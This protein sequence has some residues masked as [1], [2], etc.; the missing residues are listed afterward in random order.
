M[1]YYSID[2]DAL[3]SLPRAERFRALGDMQD[4]IVRATSAER[5]RLAAEETA[6]QA[7]AHGVWGSQRRA[8]E[9]LGIKQTYL[10]SLVKN[11]KNKE[12]HVKII[13]V[14]EP[15][16]LYH[17]YPGQHEPQSAYVEL[18]LRERTL[19]AGTD[20]EIGNAV[21]FSVYHG[22]ERRYPIPAL[23]ADVA[24]ELMAELRPLAERICA[25]WEET[26]DGNNHVARLGEDAEA[27]EEEIRNRL[28]DPGDPNKWDDSEEITVWGVDGATNGDEADEYGI[29]AATTDERLEE[30]LEDIRSNLAEVSEGP[31]V[32]DREVWDYLV[33]LRDEQRLD[34]EDPTDW[35][36][37]LDEFQ[38]AEELEPG[39]VPG[40]AVEGWLAG[41]QLAEAQ[42]GPD[43]RGRVRVAA[44]RG[45]AVVHD[46]AEGWVPVEDA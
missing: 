15:A 18:D 1:S 46:G 45:W 43:G 34:S 31:V 16:A 41:V 29:T 11:R 42:P 6:E 37:A 21:P 3:S 10:S 33:G 40:H 7:E 13:E 2:W 12:A 38:D 23:A 27:A 28:G 39:Q 17:R 22:F 32:L 36:V 20:P 44:K 5:A 35:A 24:N 4:T 8:A 14:S 19:S 25:G 9:V 30:V 26:W